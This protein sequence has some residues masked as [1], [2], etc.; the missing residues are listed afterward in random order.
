MNTVNDAVIEKLQKILNLAQAGRGATQGE[1]EAAMARAKEIALK[2]NIELSSVTPNADNGKNKETITI[3]KHTLRVRSQTQQKYH[4][5]IFAVLKECFGIRVITGGSTIW[6]VGESVDVLICTQLF[7]WLED[8]FYSTYN[9]A[10]NAGIVQRN[11]AGKNGIY[12]GL[13]LGLVAAN[14]REEAKLTKE[15]MGCMAL[16]LVKKEDLIKAKVEEE[17]PTLRTPKARSLEI[18][19]RG[20]AHGYTKGKSIRLNQ[21]GS[22][23]AAGQLKG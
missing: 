15:E 13:Y 22:G 2:H 8:V 6:F 23:S 7:P 17:F 5:W 18:S 19:G 14:K 4:R 16:V 3:D 10:A 21:T 12:S 20:Q 1:M 9:K 11:A